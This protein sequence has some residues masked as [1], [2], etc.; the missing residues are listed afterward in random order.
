[1]KVAMIIQGYH[2]LVGGAER[3]LAAFAPEL[4][5]LDIELHVLTRRYQ[6]LRPFEVIDH[7]PVHRLPIP[8][9]KPTASLTFTFTALPLLRR[10]RPHIL[11]AHEV[12]SPATTATAAKRVLGGTPVVVTAHRSGPLGDV[13]RLLKKFMGRRR[14]RTFQQ[15]VNAFVVISQE[16]DAELAGVGVPEAR[17]VFIPNGVDTGHFAPLSAE[18][19]QAQRQKLTLPAEAPV[20][21]FTGRLAP[22]K[23]VRHLIEAWPAVRAAHPEATLLILGVGPEEAALKQAAGPGVVFAGRIE[24]VVPYLQAADIFVLPSAAE[25][26]SV[27]MLEA[28]STGL[29]AVVTRVGGAAD[30]I[31]HGENGWLIPADDPA[32][33]QE[34]LLSLAGDRAK[35]ADLGQRARASVV[36]EYSLPVLAKRLRALYERLILNPN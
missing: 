6:G 28:M 17:R 3:Q 15:Q 36:A 30:V 18:A 10:L 13:Q 9:P 31:R 7:V 35:R 12:F 26:L 14:M 8:G 25:G 33:L 29:A 23:R 27:A 19:R 2:P 34:A 24:N 5:A 16:I 4:R 22:E 1:L 20:A 32:A 11:H 21:I